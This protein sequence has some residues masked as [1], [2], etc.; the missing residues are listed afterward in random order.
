MG[1][2]LKH[3]WWALGESKQKAFPIEIDV[4]GEMYSWKFE[5]L[6]YDLGPV[7]TAGLRF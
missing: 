2:R 7:H 3:L 6:S 5:D 1:G 4:T